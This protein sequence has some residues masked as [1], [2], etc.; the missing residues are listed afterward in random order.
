[1]LP[2]LQEAAKL[3]FI[4]HRDKQQVDAAGVLRYLRAP[5]GVAGN[6]L[7]FPSPFGGA[8]LLQSGARAPVYMP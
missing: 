3:L 1:M 6:A 5:D 4:A 8:T 2:P 7:T